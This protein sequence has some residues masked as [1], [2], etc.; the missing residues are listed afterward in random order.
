MLNSKRDYTATA[1]LTSSS[2]SLVPMPM[3]LKASGLFG[4]GGVAGGNS[5]KYVAGSASGAK[6]VAGIIGGPQKLHPHPPQKHSPLPLTKHQQSINMQ[7]NQQQN[8]RSNGSSSSS[9]RSLMLFRSTSMVELPKWSQYNPSDLVE[10]RRASKSSNNS[11]GKPI[12][13]ALFVYF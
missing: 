3:A 1:S 7:L 2:A 11:P 12:S 9:A 4:S 8:Q 10:P 13:L 5:S 6:I